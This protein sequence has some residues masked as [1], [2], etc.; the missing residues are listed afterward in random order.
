[1]KEGQGLSPKY[2]MGHHKQTDGV[3]LFSASKNRLDC[4]K[5]LDEAYGEDWFMDEDFEV[6][7]VEINKVSV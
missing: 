7:L 2:W 4:C 6:I 1:M 5:L 3:M